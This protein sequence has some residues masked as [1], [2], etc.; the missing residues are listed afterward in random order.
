MNDSAM[1][2]KIDGSASES[3]AAVITMRPVIKKG[4]V[5]K[6]KGLKLKVDRKLPLFYEEPI[7]KSKEH[8]FL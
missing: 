8:D 1:L 7:F 3:L 2:R 4:D 6:E 5:D